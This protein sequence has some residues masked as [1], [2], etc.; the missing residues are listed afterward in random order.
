MR[1]IRILHGAGFKFVRGGG[2]PVGE[3]FCLVIG[4]LLLLYL[5]LEL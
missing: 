2:A 3:V 5:K 4:V 1:R